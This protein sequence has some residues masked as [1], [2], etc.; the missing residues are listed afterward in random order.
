MVVQDIW[1]LVTDKYAI[2]SSICLNNVANEPLTNNGKLY[3][4]V[5][6]VSEVTLAEGI[7]SWI[8]SVV[9]SRSNSC[10]FDS[11]KL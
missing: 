6:A 1:I 8:S 2:S 10:P 5:E 9:L 3:S 7:T 4:I 11:V